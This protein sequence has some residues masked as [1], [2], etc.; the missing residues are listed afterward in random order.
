MKHCSMRLL[1][2]L[3]CLSKAEFTLKSR[4]P[5]PNS[6]TINSTNLM[7]SYITSS[8]S[9]NIAFN[10]S[11]T[12]PVIG[13]ANSETKS[14]KL[15]SKIRAAATIS[16]KRNNYM[17][18]EDTHALLESKKKELVNSIDSFRLSPTDISNVKQSV[19]KIPSMKIIP[20]HLV[21]S[22]KKVKLLPSNI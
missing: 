21:I 22:R 6:I 15:M 11:M 1:T 12:L 19:A 9:R 13:N 3:I 16:Q 14:S 10:D 4:H 20:N 5:P 18:T 2:I 17:K 7:K 8:A